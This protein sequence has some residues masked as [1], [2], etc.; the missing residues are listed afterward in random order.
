MKRAGAF[1]AVLAAGCSPSQEYWV[2]HALVEAGL[3]RIVARCIADRMDDRFPAPALS[4]LSAIRHGKRDIRAG[5]VAVL[6]PQ[7][8]PLVPADVN[9]ALEEVGPRCERPF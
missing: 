4:E 7:I 1:L 5:T 9:A 6:L 3:P 8:R 2:R